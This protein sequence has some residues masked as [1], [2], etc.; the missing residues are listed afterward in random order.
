MKSTLLMFVNEGMHLHYEEE[1][2]SSS[3]LTPK[4]GMGNPDGTYYHLERNGYGNTP[5][6]CFYFHESLSA[7]KK[8]RFKD[9]MKPTIPSK[10]FEE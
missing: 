8:A 9:R 4:I 6:I 1:V 10:W 7:D 5:R 2:P 3:E